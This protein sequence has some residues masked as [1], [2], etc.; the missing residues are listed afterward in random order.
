M[1]KLISALLIAGTLA[2]YSGCIKQTQTTTVITNPPGTDPNDTTGNTT[3]TSSFLNLTGSI[4]GKTWIDATNYTGIAGSTTIVLNWGTLPAGYQEVSIEIAL[5]DGAN[6]STLLTTKH[7]ETQTGNSYTYLLLTNDYRFND[8]HPA[9][10]TATVVPLSG[11]GKKAVT[12]TA[13]L[14]R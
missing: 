7:S 5:Y 4:N 13:I 1:K 2:T 6:H 12:L 10:L 9:W 3:G 8:T 11:S 14:K